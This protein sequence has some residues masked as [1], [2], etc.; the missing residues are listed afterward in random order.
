MT[1]PLTRDT[2]HQPATDAHEE[3]TRSRFEGG[4]I[5]RAATS[6]GDYLTRMAL[7]DPTKEQ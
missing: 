5:W 6:L 2:S 7:A 1:K 4:P 3:E